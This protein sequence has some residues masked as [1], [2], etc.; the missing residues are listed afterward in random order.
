MQHGK[1]CYNAVMDALAVCAGNWAATAGATVIQL[2]L[3][4]CRGIASL[5]GSLRCRRMTLHVRINSLQQWMAN[6]SPAGLRL[7]P[8]GRQFGPAG[9]LLC[10]TPPL[11]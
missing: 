6:N 4:C 7:H 5:L 8:A 3:A 1:S 10:R 9:H 11:A 2:R